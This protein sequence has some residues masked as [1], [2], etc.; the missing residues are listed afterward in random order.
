[1][2]IHTFF[3][4][5]YGRLRDYSIQ[6]GGT[7]IT[8]GFGRSKKRKEIIFE[9]I[10]VSS[11]G[12]VSRRKE[13]FRSTLNKAWHTKTFMGYLLTRNIFET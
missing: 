5:I 1:M 6:D 11:L 13:S 3:V 10:P 7:K 2:D 9:A 4:S 12:E 8:L